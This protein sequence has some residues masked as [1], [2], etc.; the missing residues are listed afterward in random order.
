MLK[1]EDCNRIFDDAV[2]KR[3]FDYGGEELD[4]PTYHCPHCNSE[5]IVDA[6]KCCICGVVK[7]YHDF[8]GEF[9][10]ECIEKAA[11]DARDAIYRHCTGMQIEAL[12]EYVDVGGI[13]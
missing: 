6:K 1:C 10:D 9:C 12:K 5:F 11:S 8:S 2:V 3:H 4:P 13:L 7:E